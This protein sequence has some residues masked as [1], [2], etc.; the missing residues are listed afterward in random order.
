MKEDLVRLRYHL[1]LQTRLA[2]GI[3]LHFLFNRRQPLADEL[4]MP[5][6]IMMNVDGRVISGWEEIEV[7]GIFLFRHLHLLQ[8]H[9]LHLLLQGQSIVH[10]VLE[11]AVHHLAKEVLYLLA[12][13]VLRVQES[14]HL[15]DVLPHHC[16]LDEAVHLLDGQHLLV[17]FTVLSDVRCLLAHAVYH[18]HVVVVL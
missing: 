17:Q 6:D 16:R 10:L 18:H 12:I 13:L 3:I 8:C 14:L 7:L 1:H 9:H 4:L 15:E 11:V 2:P 5:I